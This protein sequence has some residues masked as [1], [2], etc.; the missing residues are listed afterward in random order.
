MISSS[1]IKIKIEKLAI[2]GAG[3]ARHDGLVIFVPQAAPEDELLVELTTKKKNFAEARIV[4]ILK[5]G[6]A[7]RNPPC[8]YAHECGGCNWQHLTEEEQRRQKELLVLETIKKFNP[9][10]NFEY[11]P[12]QQSPRVLRYRNRIQPKFK[13]GK[14]GFF[15]RNSH[16]IVEI[17]DCLI[18]EEAL[19]NK[20]PEVKAW[21]EAKKSKDLQRLEMYISDT[22]EVRYGLITDEDDGI[23]F[24]QVNRFQNEDLLK[25]ALD[26]AGEDIYSQ[27][28][29]LYAGSGNFTFPLAQKYKTASSITAVELNPKLVE[30]GRA[31]SKDKRLHYFLSDVESYMKRASISKQ[32]LVVLDPPRAGASEYI[33][34]ALAASQPK[35]IIYISCHPVSLAR[36]LKWFFE[37]AEKMGR[38]YHLAKVQAFEMFPQTDHVETIAELRVD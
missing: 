34:R 28:F 29:D 24:S 7:R 16:E 18:T 19:T 23:G 11:L 27:V 21:A 26:W 38:K 12:L 1:Q 31:Q 20:F 22:E 5:P 35:K 10:L 14:F 32:D 33:M 15:A 2:G 6:P 8:R 30:R 36:D 4:E 37:Y 25:T 13:D 17:D 3:I 9:N